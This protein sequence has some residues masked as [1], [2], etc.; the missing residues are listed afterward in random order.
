M[1]CDDPHCG[2]SYRLNMILGIEQIKELSG[3]RFE[4]DGSHS[5]DAYRKNDTEAQ[6][7]IDTLSFFRAV[8]VSKYGNDTVVHT[9][10]RHKE[11]ALK[12]EVNSVY[13]DRS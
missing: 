7:F 8:V 13:S 5:H 9:E 10:Y 6:G 4:Y 2:D 3:N 1:E 11:E 12:S